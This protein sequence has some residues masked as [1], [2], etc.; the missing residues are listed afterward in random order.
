MI[1]LKKLREYTNNKKCIKNSSIKV[2][3]FIERFLRR[4]SIRYQ[5]PCNHSNNRGIKVQL[6]R[7]NVFKALQVNYSF[8]EKELSSRSITFSKLRKNK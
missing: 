1:K 5:L 4:K 7:G 3:P 8:N 6:Y 2:F